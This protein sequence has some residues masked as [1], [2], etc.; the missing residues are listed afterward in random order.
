MRLESLSPCFS[1]TSLKCNLTNMYSHNGRFLLSVK[2]KSYDYI[3][4]FHGAKSV[5]I[6]LTKIWDAEHFL[7][8]FLVSNCINST[9]PCIASSFILAKF[10]GRTNSGSLLMMLELFI[11]SFLLLKWVFF[12][13]VYP[14]YGFSSLLPVPPPS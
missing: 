5:A 7:T 2:D 10:L 12:C 11:S 3:I 6:T 4:V 8:I 9:C 14:D 1:T 13:T